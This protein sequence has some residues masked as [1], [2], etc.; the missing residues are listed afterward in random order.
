MECPRCKAPIDTAPGPGGFILCPGCGVRLM[1]KADALRTAGGT[2]SGG[3][4]TGGAPPQNPAG[5]V[6]P[7]APAKK[8]PRIGEETARSG[9]VAQ[10]LE[11]K[12]PEKPHPATT[13]DAG[14]RALERVLEELQAL[15]DGQEQILVLLRAGA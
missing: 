2:T 6:P 10:R 12:P 11:D 5:A 9:K 15:R 4:S 3:T 1:A 14:S 7:G 8:I 13:S